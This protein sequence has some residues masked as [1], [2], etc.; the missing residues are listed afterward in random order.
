MPKALDRETDLVTARIYADDMEHLRI[1]YQGTGYNA[2]IRA[3]VA[4]HVRKLRA[5]TAEN[6]EGEALTK[7]ELESV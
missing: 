5:R 6:L 3:L 4:R 7:E 1:C 2:V